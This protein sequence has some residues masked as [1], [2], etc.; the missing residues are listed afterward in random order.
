M[1]G[2]APDLELA[3]TRVAGRDNHV[4]WAPVALLSVVALVAGLGVAG[5]HPAPSAPEV[6]ALTSA[7]PAPPVETRASLA[8][9][10]APRRTLG[11]DGLMGSLTLDL[12]PAAP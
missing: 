3:V 4:R 5:Q 9:V 11:E 6:V 2:S 7:S 10:V 8:P 1:N 12:P